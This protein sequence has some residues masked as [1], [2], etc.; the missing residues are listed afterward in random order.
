MRTGV[1]VGGTFTDLVTI[2]NGKFSVVKVPST[3]TS[4]DKGAI[5]ALNAAQA[6]VSAIDDLVHGSTVATNAVLERKG[7]RVAMIVTRGTRD[8][9]AI[10]RHERAAIYDLNYKKP[11]PL[12]ERRHIFE[13]DERID[14][15]GRVL[16]PIDRSMAAGGLSKFL[17]SDAFD[18]VAVCL[19][20]SYVNPA[21]ERVL[22]EL[23]GEIAGD[24]PVTCSID[25]SPEFRE[26][27]RMS[28][29]ALAA[30]V[31]PTI[32]SYL[33]RFVSTL[34]ADGFDGT[35][36]VM[37]SNGGR[38]PAKAMGKHAASALY[39]G[40]AAGVTGAAATAAMSGVFDVIT[41]DMGGTSTDVSLVIDGEPQMSAQTRIDGLPVRVPVTDIAT[42]GAGGGSIA[43]IDDG[44]LLRVGPQSAGALPGPACYGRGGQQATVTDAHLVRGTVRAEAF[45][46]GRMPLDLAAAQRVMAKLAE[47]LDMPL[48]EVADA[49]IQIAEAN[50]VRAIQ[51]VTTERGHDPRDFVLV[52]FGGAGGLHA[53][54]V[55]E[56]LG[57]GRILVPLNS[58]VLSAVGLIMADYKTDRA[59]T[60][61]V[62]LGEESLPQICET[63]DGLIDQSRQYLVREGVRGNPQFDLALEMRYVG[64]AFELTVPV[65]RVV[66]EL[67]VAG[68]AN[69]FASAHHRVFEFS[70]PPD[71]AVEVVTM[72]VSTR[73]PAQGIGDVSGVHDSPGA[74]AR[75]EVSVL[76]AGQSHCCTV[77]S[78]G[79]LPGKSTDAVG[80][81][82]LIE[83]DTATI[84]VPPAWFVH[85]DPTG[86]LLMNRKG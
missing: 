41:L 79:Q 42:V 54:R 57:I 72:R 70:K 3:P 2:H 11:K 48:A 4:P 71:K 26:Y 75:A 51:H 22:Q 80:G 39:S 78:R 86:N 56:D 49:V 55:A 24:L 67:S 43:W 69:R 1:E 37:Q 34:R 36:S 50:I 12:V 81:P 76:E 52:P 18:V 13:I 5:D 64:Q 25:I 38:V 33:S 16:L 6:P 8:L 17:A 10:Q 20:N 31:Q 30:Y 46:G 47:Q 15:D 14:A 77:V 40:P 74:T 61:P 9:L 73:I 68:I 29:T 62:V 83:D 7:A 85:R 27:E 84:Y 58:G 32:D 63:L 19:I 66:S 59:K 23:L 65:G 21:H 53:A 60:D 44:G 82:L 35:F 28:T 45:L